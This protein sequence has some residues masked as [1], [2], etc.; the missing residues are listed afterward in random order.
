LGLG[1]ILTTPFYTD[2]RGSVAPIA[3]RK[4]IKDRSKM[5][6]AELEQAVS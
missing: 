4:N 6:K 1:S 3:R 2:R 5:S